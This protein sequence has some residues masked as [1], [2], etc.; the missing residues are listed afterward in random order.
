MSKLKKTHKVLCK[1]DAK[2]RFGT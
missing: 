2:A 1:H